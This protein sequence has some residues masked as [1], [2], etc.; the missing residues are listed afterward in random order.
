MATNNF[1][2]TKSF[3]AGSKANRTKVYL[4]E[5]AAAREAKLREE[6][7]TILAREQEHFGRAGGQGG[8]GGG[9]R[10][11]LAFMYSEPRFATAGV[12]KAE[13]QRREPS[14]REGWCGR[15]NVR[16][17]DASSE[18]CPLRGAKDEN[19]FAE[20][21]EDPLRLIERRK[22]ELREEGAV[23]AGGMLNVTFQRQVDPNDPNNH[24]LEEPAGEADDLEIEKQ[25]LASLTPED[26]ALLIKHFANERDEQKKE[27]KRKKKI[28]KE[29]KLRTKKAKVLKVKPEPS[30]VKAEPAF[31]T[32]NIA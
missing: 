9:G 18:K 20:R 1:L 30:F 15:C 26:K 6:R 10:S 28:K 24:L 7:A 4:A 3:H 27:K 8:G 25:F 29:E 14:A 5:Q 23:E 2:S 11:E 12:K 19:P 32:D 13:E 17:H 16:G 31:S 22:R 21:L